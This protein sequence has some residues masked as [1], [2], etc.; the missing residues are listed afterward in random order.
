MPQ[1]RDAQPGPKNQDSAR[2]QYRYDWRWRRSKLLPGE[3]TL[4]A[5]EAFQP[6]RQAQ[7]CYAET[8]YAAGKLH[9]SLRRH[10]RKAAAKL[11]FGCPITGIQELVGTSLIPG[12]KATC[13][14]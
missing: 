3:G 10:S 11:M 13:G 6:R 14:C 5:P 1:E 12:L 8:K 9:S 2:G 4:K 7:C